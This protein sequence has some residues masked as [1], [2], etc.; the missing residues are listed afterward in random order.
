MPMKHDNAFK[1]ATPKTARL[2]RMVT[3]QHVCPY[4]VK[5]RWLR[6]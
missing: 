1:T 2:Y 5:A 4:G 3:A 6:E